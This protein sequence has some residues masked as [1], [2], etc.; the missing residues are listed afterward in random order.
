MISM[1]FRMPF[2]V[3]L[4][5]APV[6]LALGI[7]GYFAAVHDDAVRLQALSHGPPAPVAIERY[8]PKRN[9]GDYAEVV[10]EGQLDTTKIV[11]V[12][13]T[14]GS[15][16]VGTG[17][18]APLYATDAKDRAGGI[19]AIFVSDGTLSD[20]SIT[21]MIVRQGPFGPILRIDGIDTTAS[22]TPEYLSTAQEKIGTIP[23]K[24]IFLNPFDK[25]RN[26]ALAPKNEGMAIL[27]FAAVMAALF[28]GYGLFR[29]PRAAPDP[30]A[31]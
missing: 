27:I 17:T 12:T 1:L 14:K 15:R 19:A 5:L 10:I 7:W 9:Q 13:K 24:T 4:I 26:A 3:Y 8:D 30:L 11:D 29:M 22:G 6:S 21:K 28:A 25:D 31:G 16:T 23:E 2:W 20:E 18:V